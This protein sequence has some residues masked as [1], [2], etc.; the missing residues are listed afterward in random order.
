MKEKNQKKLLIILSIVVAIFTIG[1]VFRTLQNDTFFNIAIG[2]HLLENGIDMKEHFTWADNDLYYTHSHWLFD[3]IIYLVY[4]SFGFTGI[5]ISTIIL[6][7]IISIT[8]FLLSSKRSKSPIV[9]FVLTLFS[10][11]I[12]ADSFTPRSQIISFFF[13]IIEIYC[14]EKFIETNKLK[15]AIILIV[16][17]ILVANI[18]AATWPLILVL[19]MPYIAASACNLLTSK[20][21]YSQLIKRLD[22]KIKK[23]PETSK[24]IAEYQKD[25]EDYRRIIEERKSQYLEYKVIRKENYNTRNLIILMIIISLTGLI[26][27]IHDTPYTYILKSMFGPSNF[28]DGSI[29]INYIAEMQP[30]VPV[31]NAAFLLFTIIFI[32]FLAF[33][34]TKIKTEHGLLMAGLYLMSLTSGR[35]IYLLVFL[36]T[37]VLT[38]LITYATNLLIPDDIKILEKILLH[39]VA[40]FLLFFMVVPYTSLQLVKRSEI[41]YVNE[42]LY[43]T[44]AVEYIKENIDYENMRIYNS[45]NYGSY[46]MLHDIPVFIDSRLD[47]YCSEFN[48][49]DIFKDYIQVSSGKV[50]YDDVFDKYDFTHILLY[51]DELLYKYLVKDISYDV[52]YEDEYFA[53]F[54]KN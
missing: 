35:Y 4:N 2:E 44:K 42:S 23:L 51:K 20:F 46:L 8:L 31:S 18:H 13:F 26:T 25:I 21:I 34:P 40:I 45:Y 3:I 32:G 39:P 7:C 28:N 30:I 1:V 49:T 27:P 12:I 24:K 53:L 16:G 50:H 11:Y 14:I 10:V 9:A 33:L 5:Y 38:D 15:Y 36:G 48:D 37:Y 52:I 43:P 6:S 19:F 41:S 29:S 22:K 47:V 54:T 17:S